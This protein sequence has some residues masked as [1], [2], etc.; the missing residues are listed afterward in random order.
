MEYFTD[1]FNIFCS[2]QVHQLHSL[3]FMLIPHVEKS[4]MSDSLAK[5]AHYNHNTVLL[6]AVEVRER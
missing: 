3:R 5:T 6:S 1:P 4:H 2:S